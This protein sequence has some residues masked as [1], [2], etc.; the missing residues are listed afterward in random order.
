MIHGWLNIDKPLGISSARV[1][2]QVKRIFNV[3]KA[4]HL[5]TLDPLASGVLPIAL[6]EATKTIPYLNFHL[7]AYEFTV[8]WGEQR[9]TDD[10]NGEVVE[11]SSVKPDFD[12]INC[13]MKN[14]IG[15]IM[16]APPEFSALK[17]NGVRAYKLARGGQ[18]VNIKPRLIQVHELKLVSMDYV[19]NSANFSMVC[20]SGVYVRSIARDLGIALNCFGHVT[21]LRRTMVGDFKQDDSLTIDQLTE[22][23]KIISVASILQT[24]PKVE[25]S[26]EEGRKVKNG[27][28][29]ILN[30][31]YDLENYD[32]CYAVVGDLPIAIC[33][34]IY[35]YIRPIRVFNI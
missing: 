26:A 3:K 1:V 24:I 35:G 19:N 20:G 33:N 22:K 27:Q 14:F 11:S 29:I 7:K 5:G 8:K 2:S 25:V 16:Q 21:E 32:I 6:S 31:L 18:K 28:E 23:T 9:T 10:S 34:F 15:E 13:A 30:H 17:I 12:Q 4:G